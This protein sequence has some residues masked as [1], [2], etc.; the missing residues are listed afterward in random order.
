MPYFYIA[1]CAD[2]SLYCGSCK[3]LQSREDTHNT[4]KGAKYTRSRRPVKISYSEEFPTLSEAMRREA[5]V[6]RWPK[7]R[8]EMLMRKHIQQ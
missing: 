8:K 7:D 4:G 2:C 6:K 1:R 5:E 3:D